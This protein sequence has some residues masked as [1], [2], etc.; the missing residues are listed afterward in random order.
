MRHAVRGRRTETEE[1]D[2]DAARRSRTATHDRPA[3]PLHRIDGRE[4]AVGIDIGHARIVANAPVIIG[5]VPVPTLARDVE[6]PLDPADE[7]IEILNRA[8]RLALDRSE[9]HTSELQSLMRISYAVF[10][11]KKKNN[12][13]QTLTKCKLHSTKTIIN[14]TNY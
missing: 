8:L 7:A 5:N 14:T 10:C 1:G 13:I 9:E 3:R 4:E 12:Q 11:L 2:R 6:M